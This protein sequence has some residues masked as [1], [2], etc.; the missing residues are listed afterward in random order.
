VV[1]ENHQLKRDL[2]AVHKEL[3]RIQEKVLQ[4][5]S[6]AKHDD[7]E[8][9]EIFDGEDAKDDVAA[10]LSSI[11]DPKECTLSSSLLNLQQTSLKTYRKRLEYHLL[12]CSSTL[13][14]LYKENKDLKAET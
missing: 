7:L 6:P 12:E 11:Y 9:A 4:F 8:K 14:R 10:L 1:D 3:V 2:R 13:Y 5:T